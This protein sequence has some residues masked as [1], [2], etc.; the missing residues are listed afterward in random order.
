MTRLLLS[1]LIAFTSASS[2][3]ALPLA[4]LKSPIVAA[5]PKFSAPV[6]PSGLS[7][8]GASQPMMSRVGASQL[9]QLPPSAAFSGA[10]GS[11]GASRVQR[12]SGVLSQIETGDVPG[13]GVNFDGIAP[14][15][16]RAVDVEPINSASQL[17]RLVPNLGNSHAMHTAL[18]SSAGP[19][20]AHVYH[21]AYGG[22]FTSLA[23]AAHPDSIRRLMAPHEFDTVK[24]LLM[25]TKD[26]EV[27]VLEDGPNPDLIVGGVVTEMKKV[28]GLGQVRV[29]LAHAN[30]QL[31]AHARRHGL[32]PGAVVLDLFLPKKA[33]PG[34]LSS[35]IT[36]VARESA[37]VGFD[38]VYVFYKDK[39]SIYTSRSG[40]VFRA[41]RRPRGDK[42][43]GL[44]ERQGLFPA[45]F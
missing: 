8:N 2:A 28:I 17:G 44:V 9:L 43:A 16:V 24:K 5:V 4:K 29:Q 21:D 32:G 23:L 27:L 3:A 7:P 42:R 34:N 45:A 26:L 11:R 30:E 37:E 12:P 14:V 41:L 38:R 22:R 6:S 20:N 13:P 1:A 33:S 18:E 10:G 39:L 15:G 25:R 35:V 36:R 40:G 31:L 19:F